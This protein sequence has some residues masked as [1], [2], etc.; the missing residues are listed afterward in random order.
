MTACDIAAITKPWE[1]QQRVA[2]LVAS[3]FFEQGDMERTDL[4]I[5]PMV[6]TYQQ[7]LEQLHIYMVSIETSL[8]IS[9]CSV[10]HLTSDPDGPLSSLLVVS[11]PNQLLIMHGKCVYIL[12]SA[13]RRIYILPVFCCINFTF[14]RNHAY[15]SCR[16]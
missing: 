10:T 4:N 16:L 5:E 11:L 15:A 13:L 8:Q 3:E 7:Q 6:S 2:V 1:I 14:S 9:L 12:C